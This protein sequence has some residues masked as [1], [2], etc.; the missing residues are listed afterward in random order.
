VSRWLRVS[1]VLAAAAFVV[2]FRV[3]AEEDDAPAEAALSTSRAS[4]ALEADAAKSPVRPAAQVQLA[5]VAS[6]PALQGEPESVVEARKQ[7]AEAAKREKARKKAAAER[8]KKAAAKR[9]KAA[10][11]KRKRE[12]AARKKREAAARKRAAAAPPVVA[13]APTAV[14]QA[15]RRVV[16]QAPAPVYTP[17]K[18]KGYVGKDFDSRG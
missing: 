14:P 1:C 15:P 6:L 3:H 11:A 10:A 18:P 16:P 4:A 8:R 9:H 17:P 7:R 5:A 2:G 12:A 13:P